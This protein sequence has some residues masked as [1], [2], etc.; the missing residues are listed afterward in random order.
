MATHDHRCRHA[1]TVIVHGLIAADPAPSLAESAAAI[2]TAAGPN[3]DVSLEVMSS[4]AAP[5]E[6]FILI[7]GPGTEAAAR[8]ITTAHA[9]YGLA[10]ATLTDDLNERSR[11]VD[12]RDQTDITTATTEIEGM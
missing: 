9:H 3:L 6:V 2:T 7:S 1:A 4:A 8:A 10:R 11:P 5:R 12:Q